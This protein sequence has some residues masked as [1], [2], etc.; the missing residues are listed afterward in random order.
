MT[1]NII[2]SLIRAK[3]NVSERLIDKLPDSIGPHIRE[4]RSDI[5]NSLNDE[6][7]NYLAKD[8]AG[9]KEN[10]IKKVELE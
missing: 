7:S 5:L 4:L 2:G 9:K 1:N 8:T 10:G 3:L 6:I